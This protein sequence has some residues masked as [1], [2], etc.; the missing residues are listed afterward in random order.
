MAM[1]RQ[2]LVVSLSSVTRAAVVE[3]ILVEVKIHVFME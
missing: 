1:M 3:D 2:G